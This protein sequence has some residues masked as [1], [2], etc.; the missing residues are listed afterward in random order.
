[1]IVADSS[2]SILNLIRLA[3][4]GGEF[5]VH[6]FVSGREMMKALRELAPDAILLN[7]SLADADGSRMCAFIRRQRAFGDIPLVLLRG[8][9][10]PVDEESL[11]GLGH[12]ALVEEPFDSVRLAG[13][14]RSLIARRQTPRHLPEEPV[15]DKSLISGAGWERSTAGKAEPGGQEQ[16]RLLKEM[17]DGIASRVKK[18]LE[19]WLREEGFRVSCGRS[20]ADGEP[21]KDS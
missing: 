5:D 4:S 12:D 9:F 13:L 10:D 21:G 2:P 15:P 20:G 11:S 19:N 7:L 18:E 3:F 16:N 8:T 14:V 1:M 17:E 6:A